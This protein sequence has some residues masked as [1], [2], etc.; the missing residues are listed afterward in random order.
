MPNRNEVYLDHISKKKGES[1]F[2][3]FT[4]E[5]AEK[6]DIV[7]L[8]EDPIKKRPHQQKMRSLFIFLTKQHQWTKKTLHFPQI[9]PPSFLELLQFR[10]N[11]KELVEFTAPSQKPQFAWDTT[12]AVD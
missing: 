10:L 12:V 8:E 9:T 1:S 5:N 2:A 6:Q 3:K 4:P 11:P 7:A